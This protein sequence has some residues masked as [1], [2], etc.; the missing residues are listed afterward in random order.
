MK[1]FLLPF[2][3]MFTTICTQAQLVTIP[4]TNF[5][6]ALIAKGVDTNK[7][8]EIQ[9]SEAQV[10]MALNVGSSNIKDLTGIEAFIAL[11]ELYCTFNQLTSLDLSKNINLTSFDCGSNY[12]LIS[13][14]VSKNINLTYLGC[15]WNAF[16]SL[17]VR[18]N[19]ALTSLSAK[20]NSKLVQICVN[21]TQAL[22]T[23]DTDSWSKDFHT[24]WSTTCGTVTGLENDQ[25]QTTP[26]TVIRIYNP[27]GQAIKPD[28]ANEG[29]FIYQYSD[30]SKRKEMRSGK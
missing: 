25:L 14:D 6:K 30:G 16:V 20:Y 17:D 2:Y 24:K 11:K 8:G 26:K 1:K 19:T 10:V 28:E 18:N 21:N 4:D 15:Q 27:L 5:L 12:K 9:E 23:N 3:I 22:D 13:L 29:M 7:D